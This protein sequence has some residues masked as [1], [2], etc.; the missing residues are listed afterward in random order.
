M[1]ACMPVYTHTHIHKDRRERKWE[2]GRRE[3]IWDSTENTDLKASE[4]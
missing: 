3:H 2:G 1:Y 4:F